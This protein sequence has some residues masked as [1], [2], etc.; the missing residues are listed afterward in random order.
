MT[1]RDRTRYARAIERC[2]SGLREAP[3]VL[4]PR[5]WALICDWFD[6]D[7]P[8]D[9]VRECL[10]DAA[11][12]ARSADR[13]RSLSAIASCVEDG[14]ITVRAGRISSA[15]AGTSPRAPTG[16]QAAWRR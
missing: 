7:I 11:A 1:E 15:P 9:I 2:W 3:V 8:L 16:W 14:W 4:S 5:D 10:E 12:R 6:R 13:P